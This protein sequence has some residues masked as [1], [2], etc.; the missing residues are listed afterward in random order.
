MNKTI[1][2]GFKGQV[3]NKARRPLGLT[4]HATPHPSLHLL[5]HQNLWLPK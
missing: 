3:F 2:Q 5:L 4:P 1:I